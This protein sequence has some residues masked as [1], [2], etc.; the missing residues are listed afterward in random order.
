MRINEDLACL[1][2]ILPKSLQDT[3]R[4]HP[5]KD[6]LIEIVMDLGRR[7]EARFPT[8]PEYL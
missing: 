3:I 1:I 8:H 4:Q 7:P 6:T 5:E 2:D